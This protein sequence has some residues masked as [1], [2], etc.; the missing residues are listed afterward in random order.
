MMPVVDCRWPREAERLCRGSRIIG[1]ENH[2]LLAGKGPGRGPT[3]DVG[4][5]ALKATI[6]TGNFQ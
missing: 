6:D 2:G 5:P 3:G 1:I 4:S